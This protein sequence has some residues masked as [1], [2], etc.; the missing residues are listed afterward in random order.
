[1]KRITALFFVLR[2]GLCAT[3]FAQSALD[4]R[5]KSCPESSVT[6]NN[7]ALTINNCHN[8]KDLQISAADADRVILDN[9]KL[10]SLSVSGVSSVTITNSEISGTLSVSDVATLVVQGSNLSGIW[11]DG[12]SDARYIGNEIRANTSNPVVMVMS[13]DPKCNLD[14]GFSGRNYFERNIIINERS[15]EFDRC[16]AVR[17]MCSSDNIFVNNVIYSIDCMGAYLRDN[18]D[19]NEFRGNF[20]WKRTRTTGFGSPFEFADGNTDKHEPAYNKITSNVIRSDAG[21]AIVEAIQSGGNEYTYNEIISNGS[22][23]AWLRVDPSQINPGHSP[24]I[25]GPKSVFRNNTFYS[26]NGPAVS[27][28]TISTAA[29]RTPTN[30]EFKSNIVASTGSSIFSYADRGPIAWPDN[31]AW[32]NFRSDY[33]IFYLLS[34][35]APSFGSYGNLSA[36]RSTTGSDANSNKAQS[37]SFIANPAF[38]NSGKGNFQISATS[39]AIGAGESGA[40]AGAYAYQNSSCPNES[41]KCS[42][43]SVYVT[44]DGFKMRSCIDLNN[45]HTRHN[46][47]DLTCCSDLSKCGSSYTGPMSNQSCSAIPPQDQLAPQAPSSLTLR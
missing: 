3:A 44:S 46:R 29:W 40:A 8:A 14:T 39:Q 25:D 1:L 26:A 24:E 23:G 18:A 2:I 32:A 9:A 4:Q 22:D 15:S 6:R 19:R 13:Q 33:N 20:M 28:G 10:D 42:E 43:W 34:G 27:L 41:W 38:V 21:P 45:C 7:R 36:W 30:F 47:P 5:L 12:V 37:A 16:S 31:S 35:S 11:L 17:I